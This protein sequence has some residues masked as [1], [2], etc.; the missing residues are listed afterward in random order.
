MGTFVDD[1]T[2]FLGGVSNTNG[3]G[4]PLC[5]EFLPFLATV[6]LQKYLFSSFLALMSQ[7]G[8]NVIPPT[9]DPH[10]PTI[11]SPFFS[12]P[13]GVTSSCGLFFILECNKRK[14]KR[15]RRIGDKMVLRRKELNA[16]RGKRKR[17]RGRRRENI[18]RFLLAPNSTLFAYLLLPLP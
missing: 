2:G 4:Y 11:L 17:E 7:G 18:F 9:T 13:S 14:G 10:R 5:A 1:H 16:D 6:K 3:K 8:I 15:R 12:L